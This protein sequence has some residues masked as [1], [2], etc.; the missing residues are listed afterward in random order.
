MDVWARASLRKLTFRFQ[1]A[2]RLFERG[3]EHDFWISIQLIILSSSSFISV[4]VY[5]KMARKLPCGLQ[6][7]RRE[8][9]RRPRLCGCWRLVKPLP[10]DLV[11][12][13]KLMP[14][15][16]PRRGVEASPVSVRPLSVPQSGPPPDE[17]CLCNPYGFLCHLSS[18]G[19]GSSSFLYLPSYVLLP[20]QKNG[21]LLAS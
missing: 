15:L 21:C 5:D 10:L 14:S 4:A 7:G 8:V 13:T 1:D 2:S 17:I 3:L 16:R 6:R 12:S 9:R 18:R 20:K 19:N 11:W